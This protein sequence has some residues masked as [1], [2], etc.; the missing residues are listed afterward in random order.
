MGFLDNLNGSKNLVI[1]TSSSNVK[2][3]VG[4]YNSKMQVVTIDKAG[5]VP[6]ESDAIADGAIS[7]SFNVIM[8]LKH[9]FAKLEIKSKNCIITTDGAFVHT[10][11]LELPKVK[12][13]Q[14]TDMVRYEVMGQGTNKDM[15]IEY[16]V[17]GTT[18]DAETNA[19]KLKIRAVAVPTDTIGEYREFIKNLDLTAVAMDC[20]S[21]AVRKL[22][23]S[24][25]VNGS[26][27]IAQS[28]LLLIELSGAVTTITILDKGFPVLSR[29]LQF[30]HSNIRQVAESVKKMQGG[31]ETQSSLARRLNITKSD[32]DLS[33][34]VEEIDVWHESLV[35]T[36]SLQSAVNAYF[37]S[38]VDAVSRTAQFAISKFH[39]DS[40]GTCLLYGSGAEYKKIDKEL[41]RQLGTQVEVLHTLSTVR[42]PKEQFSLP[43]FV[44]CC[45]ALIRHD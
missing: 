19:E 8:A 32:S 2:L 28:T 36:P 24:G 25:T 40:I 34:A 3:A 45:G 7:D 44:N 21:N 38:L 42:G 5:I 20:N 12:A 13:E 22:F 27:N 18:K 9:A 30:G 31:G 29:R 33:V 41:S 16:L 39:I 4:D 26:I 37:K 17:T 1:D 6:L 23:A 35:E 14:L 11:D 15:N 43:Q 10:R